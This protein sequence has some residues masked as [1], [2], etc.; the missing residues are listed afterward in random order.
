MLVT[1]ALPVRDFLERFAGNRLQAGRPAVASEMAE[2]IFYFLH[3]R[4]PRG[5]LDGGGCKMLVGV[6]AG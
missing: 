5:R 4:V 2:E 6:A 3:G 1:E